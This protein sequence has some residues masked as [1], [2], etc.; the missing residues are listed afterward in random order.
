MAEND[1][2]IDGTLDTFE[3]AFPARDYTI[4]FDAPEFTSVCP[5]TGLPDF[6]TIHIAYVPGERCVELR[7]FKYYLNAFRNRGIFYEAVVNTILDDFVAACAPRRITVT[8]DFKTRGGISAR[9]TA[10]HDSATS[11]R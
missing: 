9:V 4:E 1:Y 2:R 8:G 11:P 7:S 10:S 5:M 3:N 6:G